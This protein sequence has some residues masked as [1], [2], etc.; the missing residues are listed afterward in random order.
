MLGQFF[1]KISIIFYIKKTFLSDISLGSFNHS[2]GRN[3]SAGTMHCYLIWGH[4]QL[5]WES[6]L[7]VDKPES[8]LVT[9]VPHGKPTI[10]QGLKC[11]T[12]VSVIRCT[13]PA[14]LIWVTRWAP[15][16]ESCTRLCTEV[17]VC[18]NFCNGPREILQISVTSWDTFR[19]ERW[20]IFQFINILV[21]WPVSSPFCHFSKC[22]WNTESVPSLV[23]SFLFK[24]R[25]WGTV[26][27]KNF[28]YSLP[29]CNYTSD[30][31]GFFPDF[32]IKMHILNHILQ[33]TQKRSHCFIAEPL[34]SIFLNT[35]LCLSLSPPLSNA[36]SR[37]LV[38]PN[39]PFYVGLENP[40]LRLLVCSF[41]P[42]LLPIW[43]FQV[44]LS[45]RCSWPVKKEI[46][47]QFGWCFLK[48]V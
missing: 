2:Q 31:S 35:Y 18:I 16:R 30:H 12:F 19:P 43:N 44:K 5:N 45:R 21:Q 37:I 25:K 26:Y 28:Y 11:S 1:R 17:H 7:K 46:K 4:T 41:F 40:P 22:G 34:N 42:C 38:L 36:H 24:D 15:A 33:L 23:W 6:V 8:H 27:L 14:R 3:Q 32:H 9:E 39:G 29:A 10:I 20:C 13:V 47:P 48:C